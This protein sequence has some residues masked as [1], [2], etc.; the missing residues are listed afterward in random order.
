MALDVADGLT[1]RGDLHMIRGDQYRAY[2]LLK[3]A[4][5]FQDNPGIGLDI[6]AMVAHGMDDRQIETSMTKYLVDFGCQLM[7]MRIRADRGSISVEY[8]LGVSDV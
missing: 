5:V 8:E 6:A 1:A 4:Q 7:G 3:R 2:N